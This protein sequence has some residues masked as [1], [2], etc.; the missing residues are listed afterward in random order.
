MPTRPLA[1]LSSALGHN[2]M[3]WVLHLGG[4]GLIPLGLLDN[5]VV[6]VPGSMDVATVLLAARDKHLWFY[7]AG[8]ATIGSVIGGYLT[9]RIARTGGRE[10]LR[11]RFSQRNVQ[12]ILKTFE[13][14]GFASIVIPAILPPPLPTVPFLIAAGA[15]QYCRTK[16]LTA[17]TI[18]RLARYSILAFLG[19][20]Y[21]RQIISLF[22]R[23]GR[24]VLL[25]AVGVGVAT[26]IIILLVQRHGRRSS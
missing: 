2:V 25:I 10:A 24:A 12:K 20:T 14:W 19:A 18:G 15:M 26:I 9:Y 21:G 16:F 1:T 22:S 4:I 17:L 5:S 6:P 11:K 13:R 3:A 8:L 23:H 7:Y